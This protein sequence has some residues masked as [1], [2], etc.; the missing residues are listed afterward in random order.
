MEFARQNRLTARERAL[1]IRDGTVQVAVEQNRSCLREYERAHQ[2]RQARISPSRS[3]G[4]VESP[5][6]RR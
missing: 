6:R 4:D 5:P 2:D 3:T 1:N